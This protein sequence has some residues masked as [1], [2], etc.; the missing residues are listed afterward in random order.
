[1]VQVVKQLPSLQEALG[2]RF[3]THYWK[4]N[5]KQPWFRSMGK[6]NRK[7]I[8]SIYSVTKKIFP[9]SLF[10]NILKCINAKMIYRQ[11]MIID[12]R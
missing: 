1:M 3:N 5:K 2:L 12:D 4:K 6:D 11:M 7:I 10:I 8:L 9:C